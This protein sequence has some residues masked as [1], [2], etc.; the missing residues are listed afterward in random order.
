MNKV[1]I[2][3]W[4]LAVAVMAC[5][6]SSV[7]EISDPD[8]GGGAPID[9][10][11]TS[12]ADAGLPPGDGGAADASGDAA[13]ADAATADRRIDPIE[14]GRSWTYTVKVLGFYPACAA[15]TH[16]STAKSA[17]TR[18]GK[19]AITVS[20]LCKNAGDF[21]YAVEGDRVFSYVAGWR[22]ALDAPV[23]E[24]HRWTD[25]LRDYVWEAKGTRTV[26]AGTFD[27]CWSAKVVASYPS[28]TVFCRGVGPV[29]WH[30]EDGFG[31]GYEAVL[32][33]K[34]F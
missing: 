18:D 8:G 33:A 24:G 19:R 1:G 9:S 20:S 29:E 23:A 30:Y 26:P 34:S 25:G 11:P 16:V 10:G 21:D 32:T 28:Y 3:A 27:E 6:G 2:V 31:N 13:K 14:V 15:G 5:G 12:P 17:A 4:G 7:S 22:L